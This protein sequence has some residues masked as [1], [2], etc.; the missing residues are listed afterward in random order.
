MVRSELIDLT[1]KVLINLKKIPEGEEKPSLQ[2]AAI[3]YQRLDGLY[4]FSSLVR[5]FK[6][7]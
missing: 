7:T 1:K 2:D 4:V 5:S 6:S 3:L